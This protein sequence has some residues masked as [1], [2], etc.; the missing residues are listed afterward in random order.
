MARARN[1]TLREA[2]ADGA[3]MREEIAQMA[4]RANAL[5]AERDEALRE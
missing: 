5:Q 1:E 2:A 3:R 4:A